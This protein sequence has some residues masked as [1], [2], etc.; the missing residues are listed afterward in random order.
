MDDIESIE[1]VLN[2]LQERIFKTAYRG[3]D[4]YVKLLSKSKRN[5]YHTLQSMI[6][7]MTRIS[8]L[9]PTFIA[10][11]ENPIVYE[12]EKIC[13]LRQLGL[14][15]PQIYSCSDHYLIIEDCGKSLTNIIKAEPDKA[16]YYLE[17]A[18][19]ELGRLH[20]SGQCHG[21]SQIRNF[22]FKNGQV[23]LIDFEEVIKPEYFEGISLRDI[24][25]FLT[26]IVITGNFNFSL[27]K[28]INAYEEESGFHIRERL[29]HI[30]KCGRILEI[31]T[32]GPCSKICG[33]D[34]RGTNCVFEQIRALYNM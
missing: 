23:Y 31:I 24:I 18:I 27:S 4:C 22:T 14:N 3:K 30:A 6:Y 12:T 8:W 2:H 34:L 26:S 19:R 32:R 7:R 10:K 25:L 13:K 5:K 28:L 16:Q 20:R 21:G 1:D 33:K 11:G 17:M 29:L 15:V 9:A